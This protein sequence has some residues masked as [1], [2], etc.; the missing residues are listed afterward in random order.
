MPMNNL[1][2]ENVYARLDII[3]LDIPVECALH[4][5]SMT[6]YTEFAELIANI[7]KFGILQL[8]HADASQDFI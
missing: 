3:W 4:Y 8:E 7:M 5:K 2:A 1:L 6:L